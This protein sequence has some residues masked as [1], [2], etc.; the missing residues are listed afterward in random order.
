LLFRKNRS[1]RRFKICEQEYAL[2]QAIQS[3]ENFNVAVELALQISNS[4]DTIISN[5]GTWLT[6]WFE[7]GLISSIS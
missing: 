6:G 4:E 2:L 3:G 1:V 5:I 7:N